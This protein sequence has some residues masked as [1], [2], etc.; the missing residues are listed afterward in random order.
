MYTLHSGIKTLPTRTAAQTYL[1]EMCCT[2]SLQWVDWLL[3]C[4][5]LGP[6]YYLHH[7]EVIA[8]RNN[9][10]KHKNQKRS[11]I[12]LWQ[13][14]LSLLV[15]IFC[16]HALK[17]LLLL[18]AKTDTGHAAFMC[19][20]PHIAHITVSQMVHNSPSGFS[21]SFYPTSGAVGPAPSASGGLCCCTLLHISE[22]TLH[23]L[24]T[25]CTG[26]SASEQLALFVMQ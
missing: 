9:I 4:K 2:T 15:S 18:C 11:K 21:P 20:V 12:K 6:I 24:K 5:Q 22:R 14:S 19:C 25:N 17:P 1:V 16:S 3:G 10:S 13:L 8:N 23:K 26:R 7:S